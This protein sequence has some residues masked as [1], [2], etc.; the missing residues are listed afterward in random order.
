MVTR[1]ARRSFQEGAKNKQ[2]KEQNI[3][4]SKKKARALGE[5]E[6]KCNLNLSTT[7]MNMAWIGLV[8]EKCNVFC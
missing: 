7:E 6:G 1:Q 5:T 4:N 2:K 3:K 8:E